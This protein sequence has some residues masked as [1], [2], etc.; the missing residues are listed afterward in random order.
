MRLFPHLSTE[1]VNRRIA[2]GF[3]LAVI[4]ISLGFALSLYS[5]IR[6]QEDSD[7]ISRTFPITNS[8]E[9]IL[10]LV[11]NIDTGTRGYIIDKKGSA[12]KLNQA[13]RPKI[14]PELRKLRI[15]L[16]DNPI[17]QRAT[18]TL[19]R[20][21]DSAI[22]MSNRQIQLHTRLTNSMRQAYVLESQTLMNEI[23][24]HVGKMISGERI[25]IHKHGNDATRSFKN[26]LVIIF[27][28][29]LLTFAALLISYNLLERE[30]R[31]RTENETQLRLYEAELKGKIQQ[32]EVSNQELERFAFVASHDMQ[33]PL[34]KIKTFGNMLK[35]HYP[36]QDNGDGR[37]FLTKMLTSAERMSNLIRDLLS[38]SR[39]KNQPDGFQRV[40]LGEILNWVL[41]DLEVP[42]KSTNATITVGSLPEIDVVPTQIEQLLV[43]LIGNAL[44]YTKPGV[45]PVISILA[46]QVSGADYPGLFPD[47]FYYQL[48]I[49]DNGI[50]F[51]EKYLDRIFDVFQRLHAKAKYEGT[52]IGLAICK[53]VVA[54]HN[55]YI[56][57]RS[58]EGVGTTFVIVLPENQVA[59]SPHVHEHTE[60][61][62]G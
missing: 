35:Q 56:T 1:T 61:T 62:T 45:P 42:I 19:T 48:S 31:R 28:L 34:R 6:S 59:L 21:V 18:D 10:A 8:L 30:L 25:F 38:F 33:E 37:I 43:N 49:S 12:L 24:Q 36:P 51:D 41:M 5:Y 26:T 23:K 32:L 55:G 3:V 57:A 11:N 7:R 47:Q 9:N 22:V 60:V 50:G 2:L 4:L 27:A 46:T 13:A 52:G 16:A 39:L 15:L 53:R 20:M 54:Y 17:Q 40:S 44:K 29:S 58:K 14:Y